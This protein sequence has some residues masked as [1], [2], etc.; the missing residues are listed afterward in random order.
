MAFMP[1][2]RRT[3]QLRGA[4]KERQKTVVIETPH[5]MASRGLELVRRLEAPHEA[6]IPSRAEPVSAA[7]LR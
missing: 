6:D 4:Q 3:S 7:E 1:K 2:Q 5:A